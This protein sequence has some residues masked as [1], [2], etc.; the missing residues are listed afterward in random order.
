MGQSARTISPDQRRKLV[1]K[2]SAHKGTPVEIA[3]V[4]A[5]D[6]AVSLA[7]QLSEILTEAGW[8]VDGVNQ[9]DFIPAPQ[10]IIIQ[11]PDERQS[12][13]DLGDSL[14]DSGLDLEGRVTRDRDTIKVVVGRK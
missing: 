11:T 2:L 10:G 14:I 6:E 5:D 13:V 7:K 8:T 9:T 3:S 12:V 1:E 4:M